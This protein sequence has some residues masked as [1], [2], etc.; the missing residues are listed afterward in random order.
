MSAAHR[1]HD[2]QTNA[3]Y[4]P[5]HMGSFISMR[6]KRIHQIYHGCQNSLFFHLA[7]VHR[8]F[9]GLIPLT[10]QQF[11]EG[12][13]SMREKGRFS[14]VFSFITS[15]TSLTPLHHLHVLL[16]SS[17]N[18]F[19]TLNPG[20]HQCPAGLTMQTVDSVDTCRK[21][22]FNPPMHPASC[23]LLIGVLRPDPYIAGSSCMGYIPVGTCNNHT[24]TDYA[25]LA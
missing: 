22:P 18:R 13:M 12:T 20:I 5:R 16:Q 9:S 6:P 1:F 3:I 7:F 2:R 11:R 4:M 17:T 15:F 19:Y 8:Y 21:Y 10:D 14:L 23:S 24:L 25:S